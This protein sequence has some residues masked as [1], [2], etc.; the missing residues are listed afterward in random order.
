MGW[1]KWIAGR[2]PGNKNADGKVVAASQAE[3]ESL[4]FIRKSCYWLVSIT[5]LNSVRFLLKL[6]INNQVL[7]N[8]ASQSVVIRTFPS[9]KEVIG[10]N[11]TIMGY[12]QLKHDNLMAR[13]V[14]A[15]KNEVGWWCN[16]LFKF[17]I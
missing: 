12:N 2:K 3:S 10:G 9:W 8:A 4:K 11:F 14:I 16:S 15:Q 1:S 6:L 7:I 17:N 13:E 5:Q